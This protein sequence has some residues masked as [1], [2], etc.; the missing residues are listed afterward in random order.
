MIEVERFKRELKSLNV[1]DRRMY[2]RGILMFIRQFDPATDEKARILW[3]LAQLGHIVLW[4][5]R[6][7]EGVMCYWYAVMRKLNRPRIE[8]AERLVQ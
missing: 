1:K 7:D 6:D 4:Q 3:N 2:H 5:K 8:E